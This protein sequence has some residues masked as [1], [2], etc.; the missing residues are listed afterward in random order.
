[1]QAGERRLDFLG[2]DG[3]SRVRPMRELVE[4]AT[5]F[6]DFPE[7]TDKLGPFGRPA[8]ALSGYRRT[9]DDLSDVAAR[10]HTGVF[11]RRV[12]RRALVVRE[13]DREVAVSCAFFGTAGHRR[14]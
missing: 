1:M 12:D 3:I 14:H 2:P 7:E 13:S 9:E 5:D 6:S 11:R 4:I 10:G 8:L